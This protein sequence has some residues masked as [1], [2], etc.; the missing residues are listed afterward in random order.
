MV[1]DDISIFDLAW[2][3]DIANPKRYLVLN[4]GEKNDALAVPVAR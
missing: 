1:N 4:Y 3:S 2:D